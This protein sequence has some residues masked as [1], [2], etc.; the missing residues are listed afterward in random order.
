MTFEQYVNKLSELN[1][2][3]EGAPA[4]SGNEQIWNIFIVLLA[5]I[6]LVIGWAIL[7][8]IIYGILL[9]LC[10]LLGIDKNWRKDSTEDGMW[11]MMIGMVLSALLVVGLMKDGNLE[12]P[13][14]LDRFD[15]E[16]NIKFDETSRDVYNKLVEMNIDEF[17]QLKEANKNYKLSKEQNSEYSAIRKIISEVDEARRDK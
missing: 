4:L 13:L 7:T 16:M 10:H 17:N 6:M 9:V 11:V 5:L 8:T 12:L 2:F 1:K 3:I 14:S 15:K